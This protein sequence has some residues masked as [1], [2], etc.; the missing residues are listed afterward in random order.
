MPHR[1]VNPFNARDVANYRR[2]L[3]EAEARQC[4]ACGEDP[5][6]CD[7]DSD[8]LCPDCAERRAEEDEEDSEEGD[9]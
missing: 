7:L 4:E 1:F 6:E 3:D 5:E 2:E 9:E 8:N